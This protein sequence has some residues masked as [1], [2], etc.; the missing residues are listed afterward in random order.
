MLSA[1]HE[2]CGIVYR[3][4]LLVAEHVLDVLSHLVEVL[5]VAV[6]LVLA[7]LRVVRTQHLVGGQDLVLQVEDALA[8]LSEA[9]LRN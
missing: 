4:G 1:G 3:P 5:V 2:T 6:L 8:V 7:R 9:L